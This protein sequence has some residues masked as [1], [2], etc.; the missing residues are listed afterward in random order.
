M[1]QA[2]YE[3][4]MEKLKTMMPDDEQTGSQD[5]AVVD[6]GLLFFLLI[7]SLIEQLDRIQLINSLIN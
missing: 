6:T 2:N 4:E 1:L 5:A 3:K 7:V